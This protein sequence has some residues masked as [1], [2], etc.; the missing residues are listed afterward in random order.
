MLILTAHG[1][2]DCRKNQKHCIILILIFID[3]TL[4]INIGLLAVNS[5]MVCLL[6]IALILTCNSKFSGI[7]FIGV[8]LQQSG[9]IQKCQLGGPLKIKLCFENPGSALFGRR[10]Y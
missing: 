8:P 3:K 6:L 9:E 1:L 10:F 2:L 5:T 4:M 7:W